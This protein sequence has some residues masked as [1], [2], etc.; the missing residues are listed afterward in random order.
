[1]ETASAASDKIIHHKF[2]NAGCPG[3]RIFRNSENMKSKRWNRRQFLKSAV[4]LPVLSIANSEILPLFGENPA[5][6]F[7]RVRPGEPLWPSDES[8]N[9]LKEQVGN[10]LIKIES[11]LTPCKTAPDVTSCSDLFKELKNPYYIG[12]NPALTQ[13]SG[14][15]DAW[16]SS[17]SAY[18]VAGAETA[19]VVAA[20][21]FSRQNNLRVVVTDT[22]IKAHPMQQIRCWSGPAR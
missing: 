21:N 6:P 14:W 1:M 9:K 5:K 10:R 11:P 2:C 3:A 18:A 15:V 8:W 16:T 19:D 17:P 4:A 22:A 12:D 7:R 20:V 13:T